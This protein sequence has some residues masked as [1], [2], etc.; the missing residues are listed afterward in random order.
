[1]SESAIAAVPT[2][3]SCWT[4]LADRGDDGLEVVLRGFA[5]GSTNDGIKCSS[6]LRDCNIISEYE[7]CYY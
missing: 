5:S 3:R 1:M 6:I 2:E 7:S 4:C